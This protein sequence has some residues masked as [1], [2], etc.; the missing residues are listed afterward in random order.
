MKMFS[1]SAED[2]LVST[3]HFNMLLNMVVGAPLH[4]RLPLTFSGHI[5]VFIAGTNNNI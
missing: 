3:I 4:H 2:I 5:T 1:L